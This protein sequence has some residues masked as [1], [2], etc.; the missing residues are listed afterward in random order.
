[1][2]TKILPIS[3]FI[4]KFGMYADL[5]PIIDELILTRDGRPYASVRAMPE[6]K[7]QQLMK[8]IGGWKG[9]DLDDD[10]F[11]KTVLKRKNRKNLG[12]IP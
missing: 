9:T 4:R 7:N 11:W 8:A 2:N 3:D 10:A 6:V 12:I 5:L 1:M